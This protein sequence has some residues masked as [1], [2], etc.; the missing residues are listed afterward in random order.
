MSL[1]SK[2]SQRN[3]EENLYLG[4]ILLY[5]VNYHE[6]VLHIMKLQIFLSI[7][8]YI[9]ET[10]LGY[11]LREA[12]LFSL[13]TGALYIFSLAVLTNH[14]GGILFLIFLTGNMLFIGLTIVV[15][16]VLYVFVRTKRTQIHDFIEN[17]ALEE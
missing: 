8:K 7:Y 15:Y 12:F 10:S 11:V 9:I 5:L 3:F 17:L 14:L 4:A 2:V 1:R 13:P 6:E 16:A